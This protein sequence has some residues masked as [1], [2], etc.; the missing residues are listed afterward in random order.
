M[1]KEKS[2]FGTTDSETGRCIFICFLVGEK[3]GPGFPYRVE[4]AQSCKIYPATGV[5]LALGGL[6]CVLFCG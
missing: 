5:V 3:C 1:P 6:L 2:G 4:S